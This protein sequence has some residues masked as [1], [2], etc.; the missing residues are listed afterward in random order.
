MASD[1]IAI[2][3]LAEINRARSVK[4]IKPT[5]ANVT[6]IQPPHQL[7]LAQT[8]RAR[9]VVPD[10]HFRVG[11]GNGR[12]HGNKGAAWAVKP[13]SGPHEGAAYGMLAPFSRGPGA[14]RQAEDIGTDLDRS[15][16]AGCLC[17][18]SKLNA[19]NAFV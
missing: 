5:P 7:D 14:T 4:N 2:G 9:T 16:S 6:A 3:N 13:A 18:H 19:A 15:G 1:A 12:I 8:Q 10:G 17:G 11:H